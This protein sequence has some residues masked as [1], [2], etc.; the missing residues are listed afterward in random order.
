[1]DNTEYI[2]NYFRGN[3]GDAEKKQFENRILN[4]PMF[5]QDVAFYI[6]ATKLIEEQRKEEKKQ[7]FREMY[8]KRD[9]VPMK[10]PGKNVWQYLAAASIIFIIILS[11]LFLFNNNPTSASLADKY[12]EQNWQTL[13]V[14]MGRQDS[15][16]TG[17]SLYNSGK[18]TEAL[19]MFEV[20]AKSNT[21]AKK[22]AGI[23]SLRLQNYDKA[24][25]YFSI[26]EADTSLYSNPGKFY[27]AVTLM[28]R[29]SDEDK[30]AAKLLLQEV[31]AKDL[32]GRREAVLWLEKL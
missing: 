5:A 22:Y 1:M 15:L 4:D 9:V 17:L 28:K 2:E 21:S 16:E 10:Q 26:L 6:S 29:N 3:N 14:T 11:A 7:R 8:E 20:L 25:Q 12:I 30:E 19:T 27:K 13:A 18:L 31:I 24:L 23:V 32:E